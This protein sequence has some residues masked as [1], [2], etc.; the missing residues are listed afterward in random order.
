MLKEKCCE[1]IGSKI[2][3]VTGGNRGLGHGIVEALAAEGAQV[4]AIA[5]NPERLDLLKGDMKGVQT[6]AADVADPQAATKTLREVRRIFSSSTRAQHRFVAQYFQREAKDLNLRT[7]FRGFN[8][9][10]H[11]IDTITQSHIG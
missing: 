2:A 4:W 7:R 1:S 11:D 10:E 6:F 9:K 3:L 5:R 8:Q